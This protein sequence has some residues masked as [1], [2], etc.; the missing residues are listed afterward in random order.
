MAHGRVLEYRIGRSKA[1][2]VSMRL[3]AYGPGANEP[4][5]DL[6][7][8]LD[9]SLAEGTIP[10]GWERLAILTSSDGGLRLFEIVPGDE[11][12]VVE[13]HGFYVRGPFRIS[14][15][16]NSSEAAEDQ[17][18]TPVD[19]VF[20]SVE[21][22]LAVIRENPNRITINVRNTEPTLPPPWERRMRLKGAWLYVH[23]EN[24]RAA[25]LRLEEL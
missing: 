18:A 5:I 4:K 21:A 14:Q 24:E 10:A 9:P 25:L 22:A 15:K 7:G 1:E 19:E 11:H 12:N 2:R 17:Y 16:I 3:R 20:D 23:P 6:F 8:G 13:H